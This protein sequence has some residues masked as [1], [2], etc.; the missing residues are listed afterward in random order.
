M[1]ANT[2]DVNKFA[3]IITPDII[4]I[5]YDGQFASRFRTE[6]GDD[7]FKKLE[8]LYRNQ[9]MEELLAEVEILGRI[10]RNKI[11][12]VEFLPNSGT[13]KIDG[14]EVENN[15]LVKYLIEY[16]RKGYPIDALVAFTRRVRLNPSYR[17]VQSLFSCLEV[18]KHPIL[19]DGRFLAWKGVARIG[20][21]LFDHY[22][23]KIPNDVGEVVTMPR[24]E[25]NEDP[26][27]S[28]SYG[29][30]I[31]SFEYATSHYDRSGDGSQLIEVAVP[32]ECVVAIPDSYAS[33][34]MRVCE[35]EVLAENKGDKYTDLHVRFDG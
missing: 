35:Y 6:I 20:G 21:K 27:E 10:R 12:G 9:E 19:P 11:D 2:F 5:A 7:A 23:N 15:I 26:N 28:C 3:C 8:D 22:T 1:T 16:D 29:L 31:A 24:N 18:N 4:N 34:K 13:V 33:S 25:V 30:H 14:K 17:A 32:P